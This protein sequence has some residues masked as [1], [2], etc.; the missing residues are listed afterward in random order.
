MLVDYT[1]QAA[2]SGS[3]TT[4]S[5]Q[6]SLRLDLFNGLADAYTG[7]GWVENH[8]PLISC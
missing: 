7:L 1:V 4:L 2:P 6:V 3:Y 5:D 8:P